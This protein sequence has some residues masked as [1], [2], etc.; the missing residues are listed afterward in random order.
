MAKNEYVIYQCIGK[1][2][3]GN[4]LERIFKLPSFWGCELISVALTTLSK[5][6]ISKIEIENNG[7]GYCFDLSNKTSANGLEFRE[8]EDT[9]I[10]VTLFDINL[11]S[12]YFECK[13]M[14]VDIVKST[15]TRT[16]PIIVSCNDFENP[17]K[18]IK[19]FFNLNRESFM[20]D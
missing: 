5:D 10:Y 15:I 14:G 17:E 11:N 18:E 16:T 9:N 7:F 4:R 13:K 19:M 3:N 2:K 8:L 1:D 12:T 20:F 6:S